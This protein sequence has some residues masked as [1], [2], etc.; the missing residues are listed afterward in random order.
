M[1]KPNV[2]IT[3]GGTGGHI[4]PALAI[5]EIIKQNT[6]YNVIFVGAE[7]GMEN[8]IIPQYDYKLLTLPIR[9]LQRKKILKNIPLLYYIPKSLW[10]ARKIINK[11]K[12]KIVVGVGGY[13]SFPTLFIAKNKNIPIVLQEQNAFPGLV[14]RIFHK[15]AAQV[16]LGMEYAK[17][18]LPECKN[19]IVSG[20]PI[21]KYNRNYSYEE[22]AKFF[23]FS[24]NK[25]V[26]LLLGG[27]LGARTLNK[28]MEIIVKNP[29]SEK[30]NILWQTGKFYYEQY[31][32]FSSENIKVLDF[33]K[34]MDKA[35][36]IADIIISRAGAMTIS[37]ITYFKKPAILIPS[38]NVAENHQFYNA[39]ELQEKGSAVIFEEKI[40]VEKIAK[41][42][43]QTL[44]NPQK[45]QE[46]KQNASKLPDYNSNEIIKEHL[47]KLL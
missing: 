23:N 35:Y 32:R 22:L 44:N 41:N 4:F 1:K 5:A 9:G 31:K 18:Y 25:P 10:L 29:A 28:I 14:T 19:C 43:I 40:P 3:T 16:F 47:L 15:K 12:P 45:L 33:I 8:K 17:K 24:E 37:E 30:F 7:K 34:E 39:K 26:I 46:L 42:V 36:N 20:N 6:D 11:Y 27:S 38:P 21:R 13:A 2:I